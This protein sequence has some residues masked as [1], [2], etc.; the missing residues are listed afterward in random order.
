ML[1]APL[2]NSIRIFLCV[3]AQFIKA[4]RKGITKSYCYEVSFNFIEKAGEK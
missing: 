3:K 4:N 2:I 1:F